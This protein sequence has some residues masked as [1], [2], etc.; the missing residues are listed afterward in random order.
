MF[1]LELDICTVEAI[2]SSKQVFGKR[3]HLDMC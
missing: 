3:P 1:D 2:V